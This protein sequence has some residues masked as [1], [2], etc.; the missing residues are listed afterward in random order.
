MLL[1]MTC[2][3]WHEESLLLRQY[4][5]N[6]FMKMMWAMDFTYLQILQYKVSDVI[7]LTHK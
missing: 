6:V 7:L 2:S 3:I 5:L 1:Y 4:L